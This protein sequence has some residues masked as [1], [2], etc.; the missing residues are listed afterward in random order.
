MGNSW[1]YVIGSPTAGYYIE[2]LVNDSQYLILLFC[3]YYQK[4]FKAMEIFKWRCPR[5][6]NYLKQLF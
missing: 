1:F 5:N 3:F 2:S 4:K 6:W